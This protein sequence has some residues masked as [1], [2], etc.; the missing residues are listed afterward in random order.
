MITRVP[1]RPDMWGQKPMTGGANSGTVTDP[2]ALLQRID[3]TTTMTFHWI[4]AGVVVM[5][6]LLV[7]IAIGF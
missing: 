6:L 2:N 5:I 1:F 7:L 3:Q 4:R